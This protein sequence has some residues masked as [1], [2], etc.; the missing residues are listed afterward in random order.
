MKSRSER[1]KS[2][3]SQGAISTGREAPSM[4]PSVKPREKAT[5]MTAWGEGCLSHRE[6]QAPGAL[7]SRSPQRV[8]S[9]CP[10][11][12]REA[13]PGLRRWRWRG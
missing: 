7:P 3:A 12:G 9:P 10:C 5:P 11:C 1:A 2:R 4:G 13:S 8:H 6:T